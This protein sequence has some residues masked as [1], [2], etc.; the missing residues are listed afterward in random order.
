VNTNTGYFD[1]V[2]DVRCGMNKSLRQW[3]RTRHLIVAQMGC[4][5]IKLKANPI[6]PEKNLIAYKW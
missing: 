5:S 4:T 3:V 1:F 2:F 6:R